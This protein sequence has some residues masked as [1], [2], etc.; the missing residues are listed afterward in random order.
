MKKLTFEIQLRICIGILLLCFTLST[1]TKQ[2]WFSNIAWIVYGSF[3]AMNPVWPQMWDHL[4]HKKLK[5]GSRIA[6]IIAI[7]VGLITRFGV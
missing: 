2:G 5:L 1:I 4:D 6:G 7:I 3:F